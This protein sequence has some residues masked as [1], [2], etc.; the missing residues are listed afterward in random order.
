MTTQHDVNNSS[1]TSLAKL[2]QAQKGTCLMFREACPLCSF[3]HSSSDVFL[4]L[5]QLPLRACH[6]FTLPRAIASGMWLL[7]RPIELVPCS[8]G[9]C[10]CLA[11]SWCSFLCHTLSVA[12]TMAAWL[13]HKQLST[14][15]F[16]TP[17]KQ[18]LAKCLPSACHHVEY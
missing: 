4:F 2:E 14:T 5:W 17:R 6:V 18:S 7:W 13:V 10:R 11:V 1:D 9:R 8:L 12:A 15:P 16:C 3:A